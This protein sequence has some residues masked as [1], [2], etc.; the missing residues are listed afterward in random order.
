MTADVALFADSEFSMR[1]KEPFVTGGL[2]K[3]FAGALPRGIYRGFLLEVD[4]GSGDRTL[5]IA[6]DP[7]ASDHVVVYLTETGYSLTVRRTS[8]DFLLSLSAYT[9]ET[10]VLAIYASYALGA[11]TSA[12]LRAYTEAEY[13]LATEK[14]ELVVLGRVDVPASGNPITA[15]MLRNDGRTMAWEN[16]GSEATPWAPLLRNPSFEWADA[17]STPFEYAAHPWRISTSGGVATFGPSSTDP[18]SGDKCME[19]DYT[20]GT[21]DFGLTQIVW[22][23]ATE[24]QRF[25]V[26][27]YKKMIQAP[28][29]AGTIDFVPIYVDKDGN[30]VVGTYESVDVAVDADYEEF[31][32]TIVIPSGSDIVG[33]RSVSIIGGALQFPAG[34]VARFDD[35]QMWLEAEALDRYPFQDAWP[36]KILSSLAIFDTDDEFD[37]LGHQP[38]I[39]HA[40]NRLKIERMDE[41]T[42][43]GITP[44]G[45]EMLGQLYNLGGG[46]I[47][48][49]AQAHTP[50]IYTPPSGSGTSDYTLLWEVPG[51]GGFGSA[52]LRIY[53][54]SV[55]AGSLVITSN[56][57]WDGAQWQR[58][59]GA[60]AVKL[61]LGRTNGLQY[62]IHQVA[63]PATW[64]TW[65]RRGLS[66]PYLGPNY[67][68]NAPTIFGESYKSTEAEAETARIRADRTAAGTPYRTLIFQFN[69]PDA[70]GVNCH[71]RVYRSQNE[72]PNYE[73]LEITRNCYWT[74]STNLWTKDNTGPY[75]SMLR[76]AN[77]GF[78]VQ[79]RYSATP[80]A[81]NAWGDAFGQ[82]FLFGSGGWVDLGPDAYV[83]FRNSGSITNPAHTANQTNRLTAKNLVK[84][85]GRVNTG[86]GS[87]SV[88]DGFNI[89]TNGFNG[90]YLKIDFPSFSFDNANYAVFLT[91][92]DDPPTSFRLL[93]TVN[94]TSSGF[95]VVGW[96]VSGGVASV[97]DLKL[98]DYIINILVMAQDTST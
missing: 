90:S 55:E 97:T 64:T 93:S 51:E 27:F 21:V 89:D 15:T 48:S 34:V 65:G 66:L 18:H 4:S 16:V 50:R 80:W 30:G 10:V 5:N 83:N 92:H 42:G 23:R 9:N 8:G 6:S 28:T 71:V 87:A 7:A 29:N 41:Q 49:V 72:D 86:S 32:K 56:A 88:L 75:A 62:A 54:A 11:T 24:G 17:I 25:R 12:V 74:S 39:R 84:S 85:W 73:S 37:D 70:T 1:Y 35:F 52:T 60:V 36:E 76:F 3:K 81:D 2:N 13:D 58:D 82:E 98:A 47:D 78:H 79:S 68:D 44:V 22:A 43:S 77:D 40:T 46:L 96:V 63:D 31:D 53:F 14:D 59:T 91:F 26:R 38:L 19:L 95:E 67:I 94:Q 20:S 69:A 33:I 61:S 45:L 57:E